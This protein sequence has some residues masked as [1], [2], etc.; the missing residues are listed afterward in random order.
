MVNIKEG[1]DETISIMTENAANAMTEAAVSNT[2]EKFDKNKIKSEIVD[3]LNI[4]K[5]LHRIESGFKH[6]TDYLQ[7][8]FT[9]IEFEKIKNELDEGLAKLVKSLEEAAAKGNQETKDASSDTTQNIFGLS[10]AS[11]E[12]FFEAGD[13]L[14]NSNDFENSA[15]V[16]FTTA[17]L[18]GLDYRVWIALGFS[19]QQCGH[20]PLA[21]NAFA[22]AII[23]NIE[24]PEPY[25]YSANCC[26]VMGDRHE[27]E[28]YLG[29]AENKIQQDPKKY[30]K[31]NNL[32][33]NIKN[34]LK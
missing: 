30:N 16:F 1:L 32:I 8:H 22:V 24:S 3:L 18:N 4:K 15:D 31:F 2:K 9:P 26:A 11:L 33:I 17:L 12:L 34:L 20:Y 21:L 19:E 23:L 28:L 27:A 29:E 14:F 5:E 6:I 13:R 10:D 7:R 25:L